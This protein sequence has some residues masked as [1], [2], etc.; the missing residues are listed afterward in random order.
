MQLNLYATFRLIANQKHISVDLPAG[1]TVMQAM[2][3]ACRQVP[4]LQ[5]HWIGADGTLH[6]HVHAIFNGRDVATLPLGWDTP[7][8]ADAVLDIYPPDA[9]G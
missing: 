6:A 4:A 2:S 5:P 8:E 1:T 3:A 7:L 9:G